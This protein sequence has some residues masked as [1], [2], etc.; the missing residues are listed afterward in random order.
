MRII[1]P[2]RRHYLKYL[3]APSPAR[4]AGYVRSRFLLCLET[5]E[6]TLLCNTL[7][8]ALI[9]LSR[10]EAALV[11]EEPRPLSP[12]TEELAAGRFLVPASC[13][14]AAA[15]DQLRALLLRLQ[16]ARREYTAYNILP[17][18]FCNARC[19]YCY[20]SG[21]THTRM[22]EETAD[23]LA[24][25]MAAHCGGRKVHLSW[26][27]GEPLLG[28]DRIDQICRRLTE[29][30]VPFDSKMTSNAYLLDEALVRHAKEAW[31]LHNIQVT[32]DGTEEVYNRTKAYAGVRDNPYKRV[33]RNIS[34]LLD[35]GISVDI[36]LNMDSHNAENLTELAGELTALFRGREMLSVYVSPL[37]EGEGFTP[38][39]HTEAER[40]LLER[41]LEDLRDTLSQ[42][43]WPQYRAEELPALLAASCMAD[44]PGALQC[45]P[46]G[47]LSK[48]E[49]RLYEHPVGTVSE[50]VTD[51]AQ[52]AFWRQRRSF[53]G[54][55]ACP[56]YPCCDRLL[57]NCPVKT[58]RCTGYDKEHRIARYREIMLR[59]YKRWKNSGM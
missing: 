17:T 55:E 43:G 56:L 40:R 37:N 9:L 46:D 12:E 22:T 47:V 48:C 30:N 4:G 8:G 33:L 35:A 39:R 49:D 41:Q 23:R 10:E 19:F 52:A 7:T 58:N 53:D 21:L 13:R 6:G 32:L 24:R 34:L 28:R 11:S 25:F 18:T 45:T 51:E 3:P 42:S 15:A 38:V 54:C 57:A 50:G 20:E 44:N 2:G 59:E 29:L 5:E 31:K 14:E 26:F 16:A 27:G 1:S 36:R